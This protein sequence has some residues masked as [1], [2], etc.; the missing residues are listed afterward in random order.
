MAK[1]ISGHSAPK[2]GM[3][4]VIAAIP[5]TPP[6]LMVVG[7]LLWQARLPGTRCQ[8]ISVI[9]RLAKTRRSLRTY[10]FALY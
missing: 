7:H 10:L 8:T 1:A 9:R 5:V 4:M 6:M 2:S 3:A